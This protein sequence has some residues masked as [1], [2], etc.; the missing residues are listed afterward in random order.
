MATESRHCTA[1]GLSYKAA[2]VALVEEPHPQRC[3]SL[4]LLLADEEKRVGVAVES[5]RIDGL[6][7]LLEAGGVVD[8]RGLV[9]V[10][11]D[12]LD[13]FGRQSS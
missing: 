6:R 8:Q 9:R 12:A 2:A 3:S 7:Q 10:A 13:T 5:L 1:T 11:L 4:R